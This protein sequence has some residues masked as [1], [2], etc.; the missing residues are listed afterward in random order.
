MKSI[1]KEILKKHPVK[2]RVTDKGKTV[3]AYFSGT[4]D[5]FN[6]ND[7]D[8]EDIVSKRAMFRTTSGVT[9]ENDIVP[10]VNIRGRATYNKEDIHVKGLTYKIAR[11]RL[12]INFYK[13]LNKALREY[14]QNCL[15]AFYNADNVLTY[16]DQALTVA[17]D[18]LKYLLSQVQKRPQPLP[19]LFKENVSEKE[20]LEENV[21]EEVT[22]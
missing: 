21:P 7:P 9:T 5:I 8:I 16:A 13:E 19:E 11:K 3:E 14:A 12:Y 1:L 10:L 15:D 18:N 17:Q 2:Y 6:D 4:T 22:Q 20:T